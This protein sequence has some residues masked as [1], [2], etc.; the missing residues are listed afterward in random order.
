[1]NKNYYNSFNEIP[2]S[3]WKYV[4]GIKELFMADRDIDVIGNFDNFVSLEVLWLQNNNV[5]IIVK[6]YEIIDKNI[7]RFGQKFQNKKVM[8]SS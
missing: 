6:S 3:N 4:T 2:Y 1:M 7:N 5:L 8:Y